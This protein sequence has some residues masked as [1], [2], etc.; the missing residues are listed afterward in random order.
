[1]RIYKAKLHWKDPG[2]WMIKPKN[3]AGIYPVLW[4]WKIKGIY[5]RIKQELKLELE[6]WRW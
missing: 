3:R 1:M 6:L 4:L 5:F 2:R